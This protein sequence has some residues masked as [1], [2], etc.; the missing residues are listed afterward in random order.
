MRDGRLSLARLCALQGRYEEASQWFASA[1]EVFQEQGG[2]PLLA[3]ADF[4]EAVYV[5]SRRP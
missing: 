5:A 3:I 1:R 2:R 4:D